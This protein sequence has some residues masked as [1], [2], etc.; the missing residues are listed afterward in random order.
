MHNLTEATRQRRAPMAGPAPTGSPPTWAVSLMSSRWRHAAA[1]CF[2]GLLALSACGD[3]DTRWRA[4]RDAVGVSAAEESRSEERW[5]DY[6]QNAVATLDQMRIELEGSP[7]VETVVD[8]QQRQSL[9]QRIAA[10]RARFGTEAAMPA[11]EAEKTREELRKEFE[12]IRSDVDAFLRR[13]EDDPSE[14]AAGLG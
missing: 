8:E 7:G 3:E 6:R 13:L 10:L 2:S 11:D 14:K 12:S 4:T 9:L 1:I 5:A